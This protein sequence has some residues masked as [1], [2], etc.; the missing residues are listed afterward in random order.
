MDLAAADLVLLAALLVLTGVVAGILAGLLGVGGGIVIVPVLFWVFE[1]LDFPGE[2]AMTVAVAT[3]LA[4][5]IP[6]SIASARAHR[7][8]GNLDAA[9]FAR[10]APF[11]FVGAL[12]GGLLSFV[13]DGGDLR[14]VFGVIAL[15]VA[16]NMAVPRTLVLSTG[17]PRSTAVEGAIAGTIGVLSALMGIGGGTLSVPTL[18]MFSFPT[19][20]AVGTAAAFG[21]VIAVPAVVGFVA[22]GWGSPLRPP[23][24]AGYVNLV[25][26][27]IIF[28][29]T[30][31]VA[32][33]G[34]RIAH[35]LPADRLRLAFALFLGLTALRMLWSTLA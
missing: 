32:P 7:A 8:K 3:S 15:L 35:A 21:L 14:L 16:V 26:A 23:F 4:T 17:L 11:M 12:L 22:S 20:R 10:W 33:W 18:S 13:L 27:A 31:L 24:S 25:A 34:A 6:T 28:P 1:A 29:A 5:I 30:T 2:T 19:H 9:L